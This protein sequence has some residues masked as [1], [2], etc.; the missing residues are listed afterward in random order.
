VW[1][2]D[3]TV[4]EVVQAAPWICQSLSEQRRDGIDHSTD[5]SA[6]AAA[7]AAS[8]AASDA[9]ANGSARD[10]ASASECLGARHPIYGFYSPPELAVSRF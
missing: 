3:S 10:S 7:D 5:H 9:A 8:D 2:A 1:A 6:D 4:P